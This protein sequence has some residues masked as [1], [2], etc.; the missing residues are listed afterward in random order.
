MSEFASMEEQ[1]FQWYLDELIKHGFV[2]GFK[3]QPKPF[4][5]FKGAEISWLEIKKTKTKEHTQSLLSGHKYQADFIIYWDKSAELLFYG[6]FNQVMNQSLKKFPFIANYD[7]KLGFYTV[8][9]VKGNYNQNDAW[10][11]F[12]IDQKWVFHTYKIYVQKI[13]P[14]P[15]GKDKFIPASA[16]FMSTFMPGRYKRSDKDTTDRVIHF[17]NKSIEEYKAGYRTN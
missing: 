14:A 12:S 6:S 1:Y 5:L 15:S 8:L 16:L 17:P 9:D 2:R 11:R 7:E 4:S 3:Y 10:R 13:I